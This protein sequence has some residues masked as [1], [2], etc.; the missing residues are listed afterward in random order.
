M[1]DSYLYVLVSQN[2][3]IGTATSSC[4]SWCSWA[5]PQT[6]WEVH[7][8]DTLYFSTLN[9]TGRPTTSS[10]APPRSPRTTDTSDG[11]PP[12]A[13]RSVRPYKCCQQVRLLVRLFWTCLDLF[14]IWRE[15]TSSI[16]LLPWTGVRCHS[17][18]T[19]SNPRLTHRLCRISRTFP[20]TCCL[21]APMM[22]EAHHFILSRHR[23]RACGVFTG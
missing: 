23:V 21:S 7:R 6:F 18:R 20:L 16:L 22:T 2:Y 14:G 9:T 10:H 19:R 3:R 15:T 5:P 4:P 13:Y 8:V 1:K 17:Q 11:P 12:A